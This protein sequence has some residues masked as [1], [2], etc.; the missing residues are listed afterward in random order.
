MKRY[1]VALTGASG[2]IYAVRL[3]EELLKT[4]Q[5]VH[6]IASDNGK[7]VLEYE[8]ETTFDSVLDPLYR[9]GGVLKLH[10]NDNLFASVASGSFKTSG[11]AVIPCSMSTLGEIATGTSKSLMGRAADVCLKEKRKL[12]LVPRETPFSPI[13]LKNMLYLSEIG[14]TILPAMPAFYNKP[15]TLDDVVNFVVGRTLDALGV[16]NM[17]Y[18][19]W[20]EEIVDS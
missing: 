1:I 13:H 8:L 5:E 7:K 15:K 10:E 4:E 2:S 17:L 16:G 19:E 20:G 18:R 14:V 3:L 6:F 12:V 9:L 11:M